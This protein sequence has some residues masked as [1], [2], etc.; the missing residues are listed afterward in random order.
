MKMEA[1][2]TDWD[3][4]NVWGIDE[5]EENPINDGYPYLKAFYTDFK[6]PATESS[7]SVV[8]GKLVID[9]KITDANDDR[10]VHIALYGENNKLCGYLI[11]PNGRELKD[12]FV[13]YPDNGEA[14]FAKVFTWD[15]IDTMIPVAEC[16]T[17]TIER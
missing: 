10:I 1:T 4:E 13:V 12:V 9:T 2:Y 5:S 6:N 16:E 15:S 8:N 7:I 11:V 17:L 14:K 3:F